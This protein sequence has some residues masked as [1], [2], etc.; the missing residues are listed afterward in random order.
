[1]QSHFW[2][3]VLLPVIRYFKLH[4]HPPTHSARGLHGLNFLSQ[5]TYLGAFPLHLHICCFDYDAPVHH[6]RHTGESHRMGHGSGRTGQLVINC[7]FFPSRWTSLR[8]C[9]TPIVLRLCPALF[10]NQFRFRGGQSLKYGREMIGIEL[11]E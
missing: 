5:A 4:R 3:R 10:R 11:R 9:L 2:H 8:L 6:V 7:R 1:M